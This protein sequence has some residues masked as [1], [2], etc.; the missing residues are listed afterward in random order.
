M[1]VRCGYRL[2]ANP[3]KLPELGVT[4]STL[5]PNVESKTMPAVPLPLVV[6]PD[7]VIPFSQV[8]QNWS[9]QAPLQIAVKVGVTVSVLVIVYVLVTVRVVEKVGEMVRVKVVLGV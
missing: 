3:K 9:A 8:P 5:L 4:R 1:P 6:Q 2:L 7:K